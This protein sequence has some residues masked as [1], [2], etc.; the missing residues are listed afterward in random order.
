MKRI[1]RE[2]IMFS[3]LGR[4]EMVMRKKEETELYPFF[5]SKFKEL[6]F[7]PYLLR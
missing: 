1:K 5:S 6:F 3:D 7:P 4:D 2:M